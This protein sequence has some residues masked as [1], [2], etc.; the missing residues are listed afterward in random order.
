ME[1][2]DPSYQIAIG[3]STS[4]LE[5]V[6]NRLIKEGYHPVGGPFVCPVN[7][8]YQV[9]YKNDGYGIMCQAMVKQ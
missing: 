7:N 2:Q 5:F 8:A 3:D 9:N 4:D 1:K 6:V